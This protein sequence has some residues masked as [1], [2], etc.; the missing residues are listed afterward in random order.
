MVPAFTS[1]AETSPGLA[2]P[3]LQRQ[4]GERPAGQRLRDFPFLIPKMLGSRRLG[5]EVL[6]LVPRGLPT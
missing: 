5:R 2:V 3:E 6:R 4:Q 1:T